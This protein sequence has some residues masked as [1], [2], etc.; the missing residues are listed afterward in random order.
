[1]ITIRELY[2]HCSNLPIRGEI[3]HIITSGGEF[4]TH[5]YNAIPTKLKSVPVDLFT[6]HDDGT[7]DVYIDNEGDEE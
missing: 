7:C 6:I 5:E 1:M 2:I 4:H 3:F